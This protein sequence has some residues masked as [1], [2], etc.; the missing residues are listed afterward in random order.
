MQDALLSKRQRVV[1]RNRLEPDEAET[2]S[3]ELRGEHAA[4]NAAEDGASDVEMRLL[5]SMGDDP[6][7]AVPA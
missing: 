4:R 2:S 5:H 3:S 7:P 6:S 1:G